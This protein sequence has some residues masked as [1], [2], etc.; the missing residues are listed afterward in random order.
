[1]ADVNRDGRSDI[2]SVGGGSSWVWQNSGDTRR[3]SLRIDLHGQV[4]NR[5]GVGAKVQVRAGSLSARLDL[6]AT[7]PAVAPAD[8]VFG[9][10]ARSG[11]DVARVLWTSGILQAE[12][13]SGDAATLTSPFTINELDRKPSSCPFL[14]TW[15][16]ERF[17]F[18]TDFL[19]GGEMGDWVAPGSACRITSLT[20]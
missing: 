12:V 16:G 14:F 3:T 2:V 9:L 15:N 19:G 17:E 20:S 5:L 10:G 11:A 13:P 1:M 8:L 4:S 6:S 18:V 7:T